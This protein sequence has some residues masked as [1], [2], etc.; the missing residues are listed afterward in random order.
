M[1]QPHRHDDLHL[2][3]SLTRR[4]EPFVPMREREVSMYVCGITP[5]DVG[6]L[7]H[8]LVA[9]AFDTLRR[10]LEFNAYEVRHIQNITDIDDD[11]VRKSRELGISIAELTDRNH[12]IYLHEMDALNVQRPEAYPRVSQTIPQIIE[13]VTTL[14]GGG[15]AYEVDGYVFFDVTTAPKFGALAGLTLDELLTFKSDSLPAEPVELKHHPLDFLLWQPCTDE[16]AT[17]DSPWGPGRPGWH[18]E[19]SAMARA[20]LGNRLDIHGGGKDL[21]Y[22]HHDSEIVQSECATG[23]SPYVGT[24]MHNGTVGLAGEKMSK[25]LGNLVKVS[26]L[27]ERGH[28]GNGIRLLML[29]AR[30]RDDR[31]FDEVALNRREE[32]ARLLERAASSRGGPPDGLR[33]QSRRVEFQDAMDDDLDTPRAIEVL[34]GIARDLE[35][36]TLAGDTGVATLI[37]LGDV[38]GLRLRGE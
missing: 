5:Y 29:S 15:H 17:F 36:G 12:A 16:G 13:M 14:I 7:G 38:L 2:Y 10:W 34:L 27:I 22:P 11:M 3:N 32:D 21:R 25:S 8:A 33:V 26:E 35:A 30:Y 9:V 28:T 6:H 31:D 23:E 37:E 4:V 19:C 18:I 20:A 24:W 1:L